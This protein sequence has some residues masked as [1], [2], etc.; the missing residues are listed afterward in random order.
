M[1]YR[2]GKS[3]TTVNYTLCTPSDQRR[4]S[5]QHSPNSNIDIYNIQYSQ[6]STIINASA[7]LS[8]SMQTGLPAHLSGIHGS[9]PPHS[10][11]KRKTV[12]WLMLDAVKKQQQENS[13]F[14]A[15]HRSQ[16]NQGATYMAQTRDM[17]VS[18]YLLPEDQSPAH[19]LPG[20]ALME[21]GSLVIDRTGCDA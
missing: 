21:G 8:N 14:Q 10:T 18:C 5:L 7:T 15:L 1:R 16:T 9:P 3:H 6:C 19:F 4:L 13:L 2:S 20:P 11:D 17:G 12:P